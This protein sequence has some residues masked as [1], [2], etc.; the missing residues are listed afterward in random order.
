MG[1]IDGHRSVKGAC[2][3][4]VHSLGLF[5]SRILDYRILDELTVDMS[6]ETLLEKKGINLFYVDEDRKM[7]LEANPL[8]AAFLKAPELFGWKLIGFQEGGDGNWMLLKK[9]P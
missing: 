7:R 1:N 5:Q 8:H 2:G 9:G 3:W 6:L 4:Q